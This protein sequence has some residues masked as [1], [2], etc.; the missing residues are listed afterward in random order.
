MEKYSW[1][2]MTATV[3]KI[4]VHGSQ[5]I[6]SSVLPIGSLGENASEAR[7]KFY[8]RDRQFHARQNSRENNL[9]DVFNMAMD[10]SDPF[11][12]SI[13]LNKKMSQKTKLRLPKEV[14]E[15][16]EVPN[17]GE[18]ISIDSDESDSDSDDD[19]QSFSLDSDENEN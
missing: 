14:I 17:L 13:N 10:S 7:N 8:K 12:S 18:S 11:I 9:T 3:H 6:E 15:F 5:L 1:Y 19:S 16:L 2:P 4:L